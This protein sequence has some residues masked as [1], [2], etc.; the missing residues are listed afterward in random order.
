MLA[1][2]DENINGS[3][4]YKSRWWEETDQ[5]PYSWI[6]GDGRSV[7]FYI[8]PSSPVCTISTATTAASE[9][10]VYN[11]KIDYYVAE[12]V[13]EQRQLSFSL[14]MIIVIRVQASK[15]CIGTYTSKRSIH[16]YQIAQEFDNLA[17][18]MVPVTECHNCFRN[19]L[20]EGSD[21]VLVV[22]LTVWQLKEPKLVTV[23]DPVVSF[24]Q[25]PDPTSKGISLGSKTDIQA[26][27]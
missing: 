5:V 12:E 2:N 10:R 7:N 15:A 23:G 17:Y 27:R 9:W 19:S 26:K 16:S 21:G 6:C 24:L 14:L 25:D 11:H 1:A 4:V 13:V 18:P 22:T 20:Q 8:T 3:S